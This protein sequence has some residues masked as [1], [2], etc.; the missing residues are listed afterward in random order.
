MNT[1]NTKVRFSYDGNKTTATVINR[2]TGEEITNRF[3]R[4]RQSDSF[5]KKT[6]RAAAFKKAMTH[7]A[8]SNLVS[9]EERE[10]LW[11]NFRTTVK[12]P[13]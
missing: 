5:D 8:A 3:V 12:Q 2:A 13:K 7:V 1:P 11:N 9:K 6:G 4:V 10:Q